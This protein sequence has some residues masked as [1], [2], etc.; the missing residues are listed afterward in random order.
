MSFQRSDSQRRRQSFQIKER[1]SRSNHCCGCREDRCCGY[2][3]R[4]S[5]QNVVVEADFD[6][7]ARSKNEYD[8]SDKENERVMELFG[9]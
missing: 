5:G 1:A 8:S 3:F 7:P 9:V 6:A 4:R 2:R